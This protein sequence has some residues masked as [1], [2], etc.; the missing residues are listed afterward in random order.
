MRQCVRAGELEGED[1]RDRLTGVES[2]WDIGIG[3]GT[4]ELGGELTFR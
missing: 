1:G 3:V 2:R 4:S